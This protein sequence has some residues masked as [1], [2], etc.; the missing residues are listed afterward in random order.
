MPYGVG[1]GVPV[2]ALTREA[3]G[4]DGKTTFFGGV[5]QVSLGE[6]D[7]L[8]WGLCSGSVQRDGRA[9]VCYHPGLIRERQH[10]RE[11]HWYLVSLEGDE[12]VAKMCESRSGKI[13]RGGPEFRAPVMEFDSTSFDLVLQMTRMW[14]EQTH[15]HSGVGPFCDFQYGEYCT[16]AGMSYLDR[17]RTALAVLDH[18]ELKLVCSHCAQ[19]MNDDRVLIDAQKLPPFAPIGYG[20]C[21][22]HEGT[23]PLEA[24]VS[25]LEM[26]EMQEHRCHA[27]KSEGLE[28]T[29][30]V[31]AKPPLSMQH[32]AYCGNCYD[33]M[34][35]AEK[36]DELE[37]VILRNEFVESTAIDGRQVKPEVS[38]PYYKEVPPRVR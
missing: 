17:R 23:I 32:Q 1:T 27:C 35:E 4:E 2:F 33:S 7:S 20:K 30:A 14:V 3:F 26:L 9:G 38:V 18:K 6:F 15:D 28:W 22:R 12:V 16:G 29:S 8:G 19:K 21:Y 24:L 34:V 25:L 36:N 31:L 10:M 37:G 13:V 11:L 5:S